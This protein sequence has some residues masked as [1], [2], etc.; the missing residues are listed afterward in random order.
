VLK[1]H[2]SNVQV[3]W[4]IRRSRLRFRGC[5]PSLDYDVSIILSSVSFSSSF[6][7]FLGF[8]SLWIPCYEVELVAVAIKVHF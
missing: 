7:L 2:L 3:V 5:R 1:V 6:L 8:W 4:L